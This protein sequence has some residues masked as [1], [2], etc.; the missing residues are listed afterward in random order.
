ME[1]HAPDK[2][3][4]AVAAVL[5]M[6][7]LAIL[8]SASAGLSQA[9]FGNPYYYILRQVKIGVVG[10]AI[11]A[12]LVWVMPMTFLRALALP[13]FVVMIGA[14]LAVFIPGV[15]VSFAGAQ[16]WL[17]IGPIVFQPAE[18]MKFALL[19]YLAA[20]FASRKEVLENFYEGF[21][22]FL[23]VVGAIG[24]T[25]IL[26]P[27]ISTLGII[28]IT[29]LVLYYLAGAPLRFIGLS[30]GM[31]AA[32]LLVLVKLAPY[33]INRILAFLNPGIDPLGI[34]YQINQ[35]VLAVGSG[36][37]FGRG[38]G[39]SR[40]KLFWLPETTGDAIFA[41]FAEELGFIGGAALILLFVIFL[42]RGFRIGM[43]LKD[44]FMRFLAFGISTIIVV[45][46]FL[47]IAGNI[48]LLPLV[49]ITLPFISYGSSSL[50]VTLIMTATL[51]KLS[52]YTSVRPYR[53]E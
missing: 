48:A 6:S 25:L 36:G 44:P 53:G 1:P 18:G 22:P 39:L 15:G 45:Q 35:A 3:L 19:L 43:R 31:G 52:R 40:E 5:F 34:S 27:D 47:N 17:R 11:G 32:L 20:W 50:A 49:G 46:V 26:Q 9:E 21:L 12:L 41:I 33:R 38:L 8:M 16:R 10:G 23:L 24:S 4:L 14:M 2:I 13:A 7:G 28:A 51:L 37:I 30:L 29:V 42:W